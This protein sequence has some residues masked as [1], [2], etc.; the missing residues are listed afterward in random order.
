MM[1]FA[2]YHSSVIRP[3]FLE[4]IS[5]LVISFF[6][7][8]DK[9]FSSL[10]CIF[11]VVLSTSDEWGAVVTKLTVPADWK[12]LSLSSLYLSICLSFSCLLP[13]TI[14]Q[15]TN[16]PLPCAEWQIYLLLVG[17]FL[18]SAV[19]FYVFFQNS[20]SFWNFPLGKDQPAR[21]KFDSILGDA[22]SSDDVFG[23]LDM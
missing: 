15:L 7:G 17:L 2:M 9:L 18:A 11:R 20:D 4:S 13:I 23:P 1:Q 19:A 6:V 10:W 21:P 8:I 3:W 12:G 22:Q 5:I 16:F 14:V